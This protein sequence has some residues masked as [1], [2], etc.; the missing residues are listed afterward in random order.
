ML[1]P[2]LRSVAV[3]LVALAIGCAGCGNEVFAVASDGGT[4]ASSSASDASADAPDPDAGQAID[5]GGD[6]LSGGSSKDGGPGTNPNA[7]QCGSTTC[8]IGGG[9]Q[10]CCTS[11]VLGSHTYDFSCV[12]N[13]DDC[14]NPPTGG[15][16]AFMR[17][18]GRLF[19]SG[20][21][22]LRR[23]Q[24]GHFTT[25]CNA[26]CVVEICALGGPTTQCDTGAPC[27]RPAS[28]AFDMLPGGY[29][30]CGGK[31]P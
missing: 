29:G 30:S 31:L 12:A 14:N 13:P 15:T 5:A 17:C 9:R 25:Y 7:L 10:A 2:R 26:S 1:F 23:D 18:G 8:D 21:C 3:G 28:P 24:V 6:A 19:C 20:E 4:D 27:T 22:C 11:S 16:Q